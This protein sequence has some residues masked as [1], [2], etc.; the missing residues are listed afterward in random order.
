MTK[1]ISG[2]SETGKRIVLLSDGCHSLRYMQQIVS[3]ASMANY[4]TCTF[5]AEES[6]SIMSFGV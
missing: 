5:D 6:M 1:E 3:V 2:L 4:G